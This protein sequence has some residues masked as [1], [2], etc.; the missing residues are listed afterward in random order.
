MLKLGGH[1]KRSLPLYVTKRMGLSKKKYWLI[2]AGGIVLAFLA[3]GIMCS[4]LAPG[5]FGTFFIEL[6]RGCF[7]FTDIRTIIDLLVG[8]SILL[9]ISLVITPAFK[10]RYW[11]IGAEGQ[12]L[13]GALAA[14]GVAKFCP[15][16]MPNFLILVLACISAMAAS[17]I[18][19]LIPAFF[20]A[21]FNTNET[22]FTLMLN[23]V[24]AIIGAMCIFLWI[25]SGS[26]S[27][28]MLTQGTF[29]K[30]FRSS[31]TLV[32]PIAIV[33]F[34]GMY[35]FLEKSKS[36]Y[37]I[38]VLG[39]SRDTALYL[40]MNPKKI[41][42]KA[43]LFS[44]ALFGVI[45]FLIVCGVHRSFSATIV[46]GQGFTGV[47]IAW[48]GHFNPFQIALF[49]FL[50]A[51]MKQGTSNAASAVNISADQFAAIC[52]GVFFFII[53]ACE[54]FS[55]YKINIRHEEKTPVEEKAL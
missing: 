54:F 28:G 32:I 19:T 37:E 23:Y 48:L 43:M 22:L 42:I 46:G 26:Q 3:A 38:T 40:G 12:I 52:T 49:A 20:K 21:F 17:A 25:K 47:L 45:G 55:S 1:K 2:R 31:G 44:G 41:T 7:D 16:E 8:F 39:Q 15:S 50:S 33:L 36:G 13:M 6:G 29:P 35:F 18:W 30:I 24:A 14:A 53:I 5:S 10:M 11:N 9:L 27:F 51:V 34:F 4:I